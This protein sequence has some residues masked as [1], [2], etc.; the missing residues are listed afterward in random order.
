MTNRQILHALAAKSDLMGGGKRDKT[1]RKAPLRFIRRRDGEEAL[2][3]P[4]SGVKRGASFLEKAEN[5]LPLF[6]GTLREKFQA[7]PQSRQRGG[8]FMAE[9]RAQKTRRNREGIPPPFALRHHA[10]FPKGS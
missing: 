7:L 1:I 10:P 5:L 9:P 3:R 8:Q 4:K 2:Q 6:G